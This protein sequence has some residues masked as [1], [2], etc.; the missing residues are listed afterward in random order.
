M[1]EFQPSWKLQQL[2]DARGTGY[3]VLEMTYDGTSSTWVAKV[4]LPMQRLMASMETGGQARV[5]RGRKRA[6]LETSVRRVRGVVCPRVG[7]T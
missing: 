1:S 3:E 4:A 5:G 7:V 2:F 6:R